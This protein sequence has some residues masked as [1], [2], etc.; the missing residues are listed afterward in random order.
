MRERENERKR[1]ILTLQCLLLKMASRMTGEWAFYAQ[2]TIAKVRMRPLL[3]GADENHAMA[4]P[5]P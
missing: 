5:V 1:R 4:M 3:I 2:S